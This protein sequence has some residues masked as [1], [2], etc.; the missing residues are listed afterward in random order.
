[1]RFELKWTA[2]LMRLCNA[3][4]Y[5]R[6]TKARHV[7]P[8]PVSKTP[9][10]VACHL[11]GL[12][13][14]CRALQ[15]AGRGHPAAPVKNTPYWQL[16]VGACR[17]GRLCCNKWALLSAGRGRPGVHAPRQRPGRGTYAIYTHAT[18]EQQARLGQLMCRAPTLHHALKGSLLPL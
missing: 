1:M 11:R 4:Q 16:L 2:A 10:Y 12:S 6:H 15:S 8:E 5:D 9:V 7:S 14:I 17:I 13:R 18:G 3:L